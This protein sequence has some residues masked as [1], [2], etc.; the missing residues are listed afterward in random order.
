MTYAMNA[1]VQVCTVSHG[2][3]ATANVFWEPAEFANRHHTRVRLRID[4]RV[5]DYDD[6]YMR[7]AGAWFRYGKSCDCFP[8]FRQET[9]LVFKEYGPVVTYANQIISSARKDRKQKAQAAAVEAKIKLEAERVAKAKAA[10]EQRDIK[11][12]AF[13]HLSQDPG[14]AVEHLLGCCGNDWSVFRGS[15]SPTDL[16]VIVKGLLGVGKDAARVLAMSYKDDTQFLEETMNSIYDIKSRSV[17]DFYIVDTVHVFFY[18]SFF[19]Y[20]IYLFVGL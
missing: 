8:V 16:A 19:S 11:L 20:F 10:R 12:A 2:M 14:L 6:K 9:D 17:P 1:R 4:G 7:E 13:T 18:L 15:M 5:I 3:K